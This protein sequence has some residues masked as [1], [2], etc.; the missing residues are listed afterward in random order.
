M[1]NLEKL[2]IEYE[3]ETGKEAVNVIHIGDKRIESFKDDFVL[4]L[5][6][7]PTCGKEQR[8]FLDEVETMESMDSKLDN[9]RYIMKRG[10]TIWQDVFTADLEKVIKGK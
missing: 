10:A 4:W 8:L 6:S 7:R 5:A 1:N 9:G 2:I 3:R